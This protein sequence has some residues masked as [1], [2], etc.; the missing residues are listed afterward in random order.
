MDAPAIS[1]ADRLA[2]Q[3]GAMIFMTV[4]NMPFTPAMGDLVG[5]GEAV[6]VELGITD[7]GVKETAIGS[8]AVMLEALADQV[9]ELR[10]SILVATAVVERGGQVLQ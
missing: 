3:A 10:R 1:D 2:A 6:F 7:E 8:A 4:T 9:A 5:I